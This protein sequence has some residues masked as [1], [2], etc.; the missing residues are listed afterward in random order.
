MNSALLGVLAEFREIAGSGISGVACWASGQSTSVLGIV[1]L[2]VLGSL[3]VLLGVSLVL[4]LVHRAS[5]VGSNAGLAP[6]ILPATVFPS[7]RSPTVA[8]GCRADCHGSAFGMCVGLEVSALCLGI[9]HAGLAD[10]AG[11]SLCSGDSPSSRV[12]PPLLQRQLI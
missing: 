3:L 11:V 5:S 8:H 7:S 12:L 4:Q 6:S 10:A 2:P 9:W 1:L